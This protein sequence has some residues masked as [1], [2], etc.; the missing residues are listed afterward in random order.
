MCCALKISSHDIALYLRLGG[1]EPDAA[2][3]SAMV[4]MR[5][6]ALEVVRPA[7]VWRRVDWPKTDG[8][9]GA[10]LKLARHLNGCHAVYLVCGTLGTGFDALLRRVSVKSAAD[11]LVLQAVGTAA[12]E[13]WMD[14]IEESIKSELLPGEALVRRYSPG[15]G[16][17]PLEAQRALLGILD[18]PRTIGVSLTDTL[19][20][21]PSKSVSAVIGVKMENPK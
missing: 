16:D 2:L 3:A 21:T 15:Y 4:A 19:L 1:Q 13:E 18:T 14:G 8:A 9:F 17:F 10:S 12:I 5:E 6:A 7:R 11:A 20:M